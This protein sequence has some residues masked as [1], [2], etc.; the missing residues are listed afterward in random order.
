MVK[1]PEN[2]YVMTVCFVPD[3]VVA[4]EGC[5]PICILRLVSYKIASPILYHFLQ[6]DGQYINL[7]IF[8][9]GSIMGKSVRSIWDHASHF[10]A[11]FKRILGDF[12]TTLLE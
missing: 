12:V 11:T 8:R 4:L 6:S 7:D 9:S 10:A 1:P 5:R 3:C 2:Q